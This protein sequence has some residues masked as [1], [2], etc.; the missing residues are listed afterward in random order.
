MA[1]L[2]DDIRPDVVSGV[3]GW[4]V[5]E[6][7]TAENGYLETNVNMVMSYDPPYDPEIGINRIQGVMCQ[8]YKRGQAGGK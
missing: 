1:E 6:Q 8:V 4:W 2:I 3:F 7:E 5:P